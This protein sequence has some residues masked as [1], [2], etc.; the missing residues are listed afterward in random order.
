MINWD[1]LIGKDHLRQWIAAA[2]GRGRLAGS[3]LLVGPPGVGKTTLA[4]LIARTLFCQRQ[5]PT[6]MAPCGVCPSCIQVAAGTHPDLNQ[7]AKPK[8]RA[9]IPLESLIGPKEARMSTGFC[10]DVRM[11]PISAR[12]RVAILH[13]ADALNEEGANCLLK[14]IEEPPGG[15]LVMLIGTS[16]QK[17]LPTVRSRCR[18][19]RVGPLDRDASVR[20]VRHRIASVQNTPDDHK[21]R[22]DNDAFDADSITD[23]TIASAVDASGGD[24]DAAVAM[25]SG[26]GGL[27]EVVADLFSP[28]AIAPTA[29][30]KAINHYVE[31]HTAKNDAAARRAAMKRFMSA[32][33]AFFRRRLRVEAADA[34]GVRTATLNRLDRTVRAVREIDRMANPATLVECYAADIAGG[35][36]G[37]R[38][39]ILS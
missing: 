33:I 4:L 28:A 34:S 29:V 22:S 32:G 21:D 36:T 23:E 3:Y 5:P 35:I 9:T 10:H 38:G 15:A 1:D 19:L 7:V 18:V 11:R 39:G 27:A 14:T 30:I 20:L 37:D 31:A 25:A 17:Q 8:D 2:I 24:L 13:D 12:R 6:A 26:Q 16:E